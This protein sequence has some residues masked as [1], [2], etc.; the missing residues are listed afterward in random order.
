MV[1]WRYLQ[2]DS[3]LDLFVGRW[4]GPNVV[5]VF[6]ERL[7]LNTQ[8]SYCYKLSIAGR[9]FITSIFY[10]LPPLYATTFG[11]KTEAALNGIS[12]ITPISSILLHITIDNIYGHVTPSTNNYHNIAI[13]TEARD[14]L[15]Q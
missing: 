11:D 8:V 15:R 1:G 6:S 12:S 9:A 10:V 14:Q 7:V 4:P 3:R 2:L 13:P 5:L